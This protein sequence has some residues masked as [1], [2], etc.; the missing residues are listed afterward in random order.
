MAIPRMMSR[1]L[2]ARLGIRSLS[3]SAR[4][5]KIPV[6]RYSHPEHQYVLN[7]ADVIVLTSMGEEVAVEAKEAP[8]G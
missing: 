8:K 2:M 4:M 3:F 6:R 5:R 7:S 1:S